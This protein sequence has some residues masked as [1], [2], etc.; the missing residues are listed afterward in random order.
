MRPTIVRA[1]LAA[2][3]V[4]S[5]A[6]VIY[7]S[8][9]P[10]N[11]TPK[12]FGETVL[13]F[14]SIPW[15]QLGIERR[16]DW[17][18]NGLILLPAG[19]LA[20]GAIDWRRSRRWLLLFA[21]PLIIAF[22]VAIVFGIEFVQIWFPPRVVSQNDIFA[23][24]IGSI[25]G[26]L[27]WWLA[28]RILIGQIEQF[29]LAPPGLA[30][31]KLLVN[32]G[33][34]AL[35][36]YNMMPL[37]VLISFSE[38]REKWNEGSLKVI[39]FQDFELGG[40]SVLFLAIACARLV[41]YAFITTL[42]RGMQRAITQ[43]LMFALLL[44][45]LKIPIH[46]RPASTTGI[47]T[48]AIGVVL[49]AFFASALM[50]LLTTLDRTV[51]WFIGAVGCTGVMVVGF[52]SRFDSVARDPVVLKER[53]EG[54]LTVPFARAH[55]SSEFEAGENILLKVV[56]FGVLAFLLSGWCSRI[57][58]KTESCAASVL[59]ILWCLMLG[60][61]IELA[62]VLLPPLVPDATDF[63][64]YGIGA[65]LGVLGFQMMIPPRSVPSDLIS[66]RDLSELRGIEGN[67]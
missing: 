3:S 37:D 29:V 21:S 34:I 43:G 9:V 61:G 22:L 36:I 67:S 1:I 50:R 13:E 45:G 5:I 12:S 18:A 17:V 23:G 39:P 60:V 7:A 4:L 38:L 32:F 11:Y 28:G 19:F 59:S 30:K 62:Q 24:V 14:K 66:T 40:K 47:L 20:A 31:W 56:V 2:A 10:L 33:V 65:I 16:A 64:L 58:T 42:Q 63:I 15:L 49:A 52:L 53:L 26:V 46:S 55:S 54:I 27:L 25:G 44:E 35:A 48:S 51:F 6:F 41:P 57:R 8:L